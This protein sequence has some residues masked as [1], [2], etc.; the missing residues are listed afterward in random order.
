M[1]VLVT[2]A[3]GFLGWHT[4]LRLNA[5]S[6][7]EVVPVGRTN[8]R[9]LRELMRDADAVIHSAGLNQGSDAEVSDG[10]R[11]LA[12]DVA[13]ALESVKK[14][15]R[16]VYADSIEVNSAKPHKPSEVADRLIEAT[17]ANGGHMVTVH[18]PT[19]FGEHEGPPSNSFVATIVNAV[20]NGT[21]P[22]IHDRE[23]KLVHAQTA[24]EALLS[25][26]TTDNTHLEPHRTS[27]NVEQVYHLL[28]EYNNAYRKTGEI[29]DLSSEFR[30]NL[31]N[32]YRAA[33]GPSG[34]SIPL[35]PKDDERGRFVELVRS[36]RGEGQT[37][38]STTAPAVTRGEHYHLRK[39]E[40]FVVLQGQARMSLRRMFT[41]EVVTYDVAG[42]SPLA[43]DMPMG[44]AH[45]ITN[46]G[47]DVLLT[48]FWAHERFQPEDPDTYPQ[49]VRTEV[50]A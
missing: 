28:C 31:F 38:F 1:K 50:I 5:L 11:D 3:N 39:I 14:P 26:L 2:G 29:P 36:G 48:A 7:A 18:L 49:K 10:N 6:R 23:L 30:V 4:R 16:I 34:Y 17:D 33:L 43:V 21:E 46:T 41:D 25:G 20:I 47:Q 32:T 44:W 24:A 8:W 27:V 15:L 12:H 45:N 19:L 9:E 22:G 42:E 35:S 40:R 37:S 13:K